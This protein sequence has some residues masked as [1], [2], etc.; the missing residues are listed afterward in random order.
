MKQNRLYAITATFILSLSLG[1]FA[2][3]SASTSAPT[4]THSN[5][6]FQP[7][8][9]NA[10]VVGKVRVVTTLPVGAT[11]IRFQGAS[12]FAHGGIFYQP[13]QGRFRIVSAPIGI[14]VNAL[15]A[16]PRVVRIKNQRYFVSNGIYY[17]RSGKRFIVV[18]R[19]V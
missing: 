11:K 8:T 7:A 16:K 2:S 6:P 3:T 14:T 18:R 15:P 17:K 13:F 5:T 9:Q 1:A 10:P 12:Y 4:S 19:P